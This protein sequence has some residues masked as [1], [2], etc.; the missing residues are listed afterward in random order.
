MLFYGFFQIDF[1]VPF[2]DEECQVMCWV[3]LVKKAVLL[4]VLVFNKC[5]LLNLKKKREFYSQVVQGLSMYAVE[6]QLKCGFDSR[7]YRWMVKIVNVMWPAVK[8]KHMAFRQASPTDSCTGA[9]MHQ[10]L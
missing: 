7:R 3:V 6:G 9:S 2:Y 4:I 1:K 10:V 8:N 5:L